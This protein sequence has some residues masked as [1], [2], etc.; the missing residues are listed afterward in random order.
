MRGAELPVGR[1]AL[2][3][4]AVAG[5]VLGAVGVV[6]LWLHAHE[7]PAGGERPAQTVVL[8]GAGP[9]LQSAPQPDLARYRAEKARELHALGWVDGGRGIARIPIDDAMA[10]LAAHA[11]S[12]PETAR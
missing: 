5:T 7:L 8:V 9:A 1:I 4:A 3:G 10:L 11:A 2:A 6:L 12:A